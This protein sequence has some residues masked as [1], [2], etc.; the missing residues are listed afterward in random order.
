MKTDRLVKLQRVVISGMGAVTPLGNNLPESWANIRAGVSGA[1]P[2][3]KFDASR[4]K[5]RFACEIK[6]FRP[7][8]YI[9]A[10]EVKR[11]D[12]C[13]HYSLAAAAEAIHD[14][15]LNP[16]T[17]DRTRV[18]IIWAS[19]VGGLGTIDNQIC[20]YAAHRGTP[21]FSPFFITRL[22]TN[23]SAGLIAVKYGFQ[24]INFT[25]V[26]A[27]ASSAHAIADALTYLRLGRAEVI[28]AGGT[29]ACIT[30]SGV[31][32][33]NAMRALS[34]RNDDPAHASRPFDRDRDGFVIGEGAG[35]L[36]LETLDHAQRR[37]ARI[38]AEITGAG[39]SADAYHM[40]APQPDGNGVAMA[41]ADALHDAGLPPEAIDYA[42]VHA[43]STV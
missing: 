13:C 28:V 25:P 15:G 38:Y 2:I 31:G 40:T 39:F 41:M 22:L 19:G 37:G 34:E 32:G 3:T 14:A 30:E 27:C 35:A 6:H 24:G 20:A 5:T 18:G 36:V 26:S 7:E 33:F 12:P 8:D 17:V 23:M 1:G 16:A 4:F 9:E 11:L 43:T 42:N 10:K 21:R 29:E